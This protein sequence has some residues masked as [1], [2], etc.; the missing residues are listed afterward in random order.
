MSSYSLQ[1]PELDVFKNKTM[2]T[3]TLG[4]VNSYTDKMILDKYL[5]TWLIHLEKYGDHG[6]DPAV[7]CIV[8]LCFSNCFRA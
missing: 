1:M 6:L 8:N 2:F 7:S 3:N 5:D 4:T